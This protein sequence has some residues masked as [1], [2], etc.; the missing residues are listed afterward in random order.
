MVALGESEGRKQLGV[1]AHACDLST[2]EAEAGEFWA[3]GQHGL[4]SKGLS[5]GGGKTEPA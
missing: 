1:V 2:R 4:H 5:L 3:G